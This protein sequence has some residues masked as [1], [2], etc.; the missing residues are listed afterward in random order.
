MENKDFKKL[1]VLSSPSGG[2]KSTVARYLLKLYP[3]LRFSVSAT[4][5]KRRP[6]EVQGK[7]YFFLTKDE[8]RD[9]IKNN[10]LVEY[11]E[12]FDNFY[13]TLKSEVDKAL[14]DGHTLIF[15]V[16][17]KGALSLKLLYPEESLLIFLSPPSVNAL[18]ER[19]RRRR[20]EAEEEIK[21]RI[22]R[23]EMEMHEKEKFDYVLVNENLQQTFGE[24]EEI[25]KKHIRESK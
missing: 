8:F 5:R 12:I 23:A 13:G 17:V 21:R 15:D 18:E 9:R 14:K 1:I 25:A 4:T 11:E 7:D 3:H 22:D 24:I 10:D 16:D 2:G 19:L 20:T 6:M